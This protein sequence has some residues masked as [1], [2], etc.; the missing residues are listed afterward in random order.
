MDCNRSEFAVNYSRFIAR[1]PFAHRFQSINFALQCC[2]PPSSDLVAHSNAALLVGHI[3]PSTCWRLCRSIDRV[4]SQGG[5][6][7]RQM[8][9]GSRHVGLTCP[10]ALQRSSEHTAFEYAI[11]FLLLLGVTD[12]RLLELIARHNSYASPR[13]KWLQGLR[14]TIN[15]SCAALAHGV[16]SENKAVSLVLSGAVATE[17]KVVQ[18]KL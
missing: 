6:Q 4:T 18:N 8:V 7:I 17:L 5:V 13:K 12:R 9:A 16:K 11:A 15:H 2:S 3:P 10:I 1:R 14:E